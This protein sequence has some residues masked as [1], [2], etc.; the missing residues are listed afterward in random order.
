QDLREFRM[1][2]VEARVEL[3]PNQGLNLAIARA[4]HG[5]ASDANAQAENHG[6]RHGPTQGR[7]GPAFL[8]RARD[9]PLI[10]RTHTV[11]PLFDLLTAG[12]AGA[13]VRLQLEMAHGSVL[14]IEVGHPIFRGGV[15]FD[16]INRLSGG[17]GATCLGNSGRSG[18]RRR[19]S[20][21]RASD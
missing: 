21:E 10:E 15:S 1:G 8:A 4:G 11:P 13:Q 14:A 2:G 16:H 5:E 12:G 7:F 18:F 20:W 17:G 19:P 3:G 6:S 9:T